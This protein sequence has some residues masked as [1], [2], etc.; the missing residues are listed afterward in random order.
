MNERRQSTAAPRALRSSIVAWGKTEIQWRGSANFFRSRSFT[1]IFRR[2]SNCTRSPSATLRA[3][4]T[5]GSPV[6]WNA[7]GWRTL[8]PAILR[9]RLWNSARKNAIPNPRCWY[10]LTYGYG[11]VANHFLFPGRVRASKTRARAHARCHVASTFRGSYRRAG[12]PRS[13]RGAC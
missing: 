5:I 7:C 6:Q 11:T 9:Y 1:P 12:T 2:M 8:Y 4:P 3:A 10:P 13:S